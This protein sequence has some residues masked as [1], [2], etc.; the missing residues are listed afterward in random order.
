[1]MEHSILF[2]S[3]YE[4]GIDDLMTS[5]LDLPVDVRESSPSD[6]RPRP[7]PSDRDTRRLL[8]NDW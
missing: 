6:D 4:A 1:M 2:V 5:A 8:A 3:A 7:G